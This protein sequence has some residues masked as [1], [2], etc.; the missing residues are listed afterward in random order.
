MEPSAFLTCDLSVGLHPLLSESEKVGHVPHL[1]AQEP[2]RFAKICWAGVREEPLTKG[3]QW[4]ALLLDSV[5]ILV[6]EQCEPGVPID[7][8]RAPPPACFPGTA[9]VAGAFGR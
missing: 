2:K 8:G 9:A 3:L 5:A 4:V 6:L 1:L 7:N